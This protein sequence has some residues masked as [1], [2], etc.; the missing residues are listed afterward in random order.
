MTIL[1]PKILKHIR[2]NLLR[3]KKKFWKFLL[4]GLNHWVFVKYK[5]QTELLCINVYSYLYQVPWKHLTCQFFV[6]EMNMTLLQNII[7][8]RLMPTIR[9]MISKNY[10]IKKLNKIKSEICALVMKIYQ[11]I[12][13]P[14]PKLQKVAPSCV[15]WCLWG[16]KVMT[17][18]QA[19][20]LVITDQVYP[21]LLYK[22]HFDLKL[23]ILIQNL[24]PFMHWWLEPG[25]W[26][27]HR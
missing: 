3:K 15:D 4:T 5:S 16:F 1:I 13:L 8:R 7:I 27:F 10:Y 25:S 24:C 20:C 18:V 6:P 2:R 12:L 17:G 26:N 21:K 11:L 23:I 14:G 19:W 22:Q 9:D